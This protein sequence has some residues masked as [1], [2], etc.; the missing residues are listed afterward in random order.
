MIVTVKQLLN[1][2]MLRLQNH[3][4]DPYTDSQVLLAFIT[5]KNRAWLIAHGDDVV[6]QVTR[7]E[8]MQ[9]VDQRRQGKPVAYLTGSREFWS[10]PFK[11]NAAT[12]IPRPE[13]EHLVEQALSV[14]SDK[15]ARVLDYGTGSGIVAVVL[16]KERPE[17]ELHALECLPETLSVA[18]Q[19]AEYHRVNINFHQACDLEPLAGQGFDMIVSNPPYVRDSD[20]HLHQGDVRFEPPMALASGPEGLDCIRYL[21]AHTADYLRPGGYLLLEHG[22]DQAP[23]VRALMAEHGFVNIATIKDLAG[24]DRV[25]SAQRPSQ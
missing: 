18:R 11:V 9:L 17:W 14:L 6:Q 21:V 22:Y 20:D 7:D 12:L 16:A 10:L 1:T 13:T 5:R 19:N 15:H 24:H 2:A 8:F 25:T 23:L 3:V 4:E